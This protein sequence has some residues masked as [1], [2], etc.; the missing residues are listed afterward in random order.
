MKK[1]LLLAILTLGTIVIVNA[2]GAGEWRI[3]L[4]NDHSPLSM[5]IMNNEMTFSFVQKDTLSFSHGNKKAM[6]PGTVVEVSL[7]NNSKVIFTSDDK[8]LSGDKVSINLPMA[9]V[10]TALKGIKLPAKPKY[11]I[12]IKEKTTERGKITFEFAD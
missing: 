5:K 4:N 11:V 6:K 9:D 10:S 12:T 1:F 3:L 2:Q 7:K 8:N